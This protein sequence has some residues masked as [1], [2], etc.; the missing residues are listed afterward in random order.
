MNKRAAGKFKMAAGLEYKGVATGFH[1]YEHLTV[2]AANV[3]AIY[4][5]G[6]SVQQANAGDDAVIVLD[7]AV[8]RRVWRPMRRRR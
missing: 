1:G 6:A 5:D 4:V 3:T 8:L 7:H 2:D